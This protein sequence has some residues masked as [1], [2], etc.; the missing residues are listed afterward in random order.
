MSESTGETPTLAEIMAKIPQ[1]VSAAQIKDIDAVVQV[2]SLGDSP[3]DWLITLKDGACTVAEGT[4]QAPNLTVEAGADV[5]R[6][7]MLQQ[8]DPGWAFMTGQLRVSGDFGL[9]M[10]LQS[11]LAFR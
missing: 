6:S 3:A 9:A 1:N 11:I 8:L 10:R 7:L 5:W 2:R 4:A